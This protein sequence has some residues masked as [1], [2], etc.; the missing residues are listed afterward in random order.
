MSF[1]PLHLRFL[2]GG[3]RIRSRWLAPKWLASRL[4]VRFRPPARLPR[5]SA[6]LN[7]IILAALASL[8]RLVLRSLELPPGV[9]RIDP[10][11]TGAGV[12]L[13][14]LLGS[15][16]Q[17]IVPVCLGLSAVHLGAN[18]M[19]VRQIGVP[20]FDSQVRCE[21]PPRGDGNVNVWATCGR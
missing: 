4:F 14:T 15:E 10:T 9:A 19:S 21:A 6:G 11:G 18:Y 1:A 5:S 7:P 20:T 13:S 3:R 12:A 16:F 8:P 17:A 2:L